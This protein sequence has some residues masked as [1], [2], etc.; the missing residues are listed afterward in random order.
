MA[1]KMANHRSTPTLAQIAAA[2]GVSAM[3][4]SRAL[5]GQPGVSDA[6]RAAIRKLADDM[7]YE[8]NRV[9]RK[10]VT[11]ESRVIG[12]LASG[13]DT[14]F[15]AALVTAIARAAAAAGN[16]VLIDAV[17]DYERRP[18]GGVLQLLQQFTDGVIAVLPYE[19]GYVQTLSRARIPVMTIDHPRA[20][21]EFPSVAADSYG[22]ARAAMAHLAELGH[23]RVAFIA[24]AQELESAHERR[25]AYDD[26][27]AVLGLVRDDAL[28]LEGDYTLDCGRLAGQRIARMKK[29]PSAVFAAN[30]LSAFGAMAALQQH[31]LRI[32]EDISVV[33]FDDLP[34]AAQW[35]PALT[36]VRQPV[37]ELGRAAVNTL[38]ALI[39]GLGVAA[40]RVNLPTELV[41]RESTA[42]AN[43]ASRP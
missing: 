8:T 21:G 11:G 3:T 18:A 14:P 35:H 19:H 25:R 7:G 29:R 27:V 5:S 23:R 38:L 32:P 41:V 4:A 34:A 43:P 12:V 24:G 28:V 20:H 36:T 39:S 16:D 15:V 33:G 22:G 13:L 6:T 37:D 9:A 40:A 26:A 31:G 2:A 1:R 17:I 30:D 42:A 10:L